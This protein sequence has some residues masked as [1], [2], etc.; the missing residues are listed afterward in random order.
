V[1]NAVGAHLVRPEIIGEQNDDVGL[2]RFLLG[3]ERRAQEGGLTLFFV[4]VPL[5]APF[6]A[7]DGTTD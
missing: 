6:D 4:F 7:G 5:D 3:L 1:L 2:A